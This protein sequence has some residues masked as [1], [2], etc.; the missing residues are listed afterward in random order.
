[1]RSAAGPPS[2]TIEI[3]ERRETLARNREVDEILAGRTQVCHYYT[4][5]ADGLAFA[6]EVLEDGEGSE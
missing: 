3:L 5:V 2:R 1:M 4:G 6:L